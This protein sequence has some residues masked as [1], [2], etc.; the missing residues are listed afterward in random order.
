MPA[1]SYPLFLTLKPRDRKRPFMPRTRPSSR[2]PW[3]R[4]LLA[5]VAMLGMAGTFTPAQAEDITIGEGFALGWGQFFVADKEKTWQAEGLTPKVVTFASGRL[6]LDALV[7]G[8]IAI[9]TAAET[10]VVFANINGLPV[11]IIGTLNHHEP[12][13]LVA[14]K[15]I[16]TPADIK[17]KRIGYAQGTNAHYYLARL[18]AENGLTLAD[19][20]AVNLSPG[21]FVTSLINGSLDAFIWT[22]PH[23]SQAVA[24]GGDKVHVIHIPKLYETYSSIITL[25][26]TIDEKPEL[27][28]KALKALIAADAYI[29][30]N[31]QASIDVVAERIKLDPKIVSAFW[32]RT[33]FDLTL[34]KPAVVKLLEEQA[35]WAVENKL[36]RPDATIPDFSKVVVTDIYEKAIGK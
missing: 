27:L 23:L 20:T 2:S 30:A 10:P 15:E 8:S 18:L 28:V 29:K 9:A 32:N 6:A 12:F 34:D 26:S 16:K 24:Q 1:Q 4:T 3:L 25:Q 11:R 17:G 22:E 14:S 13:D 33:K 35:K 7:G 21:D 31:P 5:S 19:I 36:T